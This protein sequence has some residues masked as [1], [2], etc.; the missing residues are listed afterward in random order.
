MTGLRH[1]VFVTPA[2]PQSSGTLNLPDGEPMVWSPLATTLIHGEYDAVLVDP[3]FTTDTTREVLA[4]VEKTGRDLTDICITHGHGD[5]W[6]GVPVLLERFPEAVVRATAGTKAHMT[7]LAT[8]EA[9]GP[10]FT[11]QGRSSARSR[12]LGA[13]RPTSAAA[14]AEPGRA[15][16]QA[17]RRREAAHPSLLPDRRPSG[18]AQA[19]APAGQL[20]APP[21]RAPTGRHLQADRD[22]FPANWSN[23]FH[24]TAVRE[25]D[26]A[27]PISVGVTP[28]AKTVVRGSP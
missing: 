7:A 17:A 19:D 4:W 6:L 15:P 10:S 27:F 25:R 16:G 23:S 9:R 1:D 28:H 5:H 13:C 26:A 21:W 14:N 22:G 12:R 24:P 3:P 20:P 8:P 11:P 2:V 18:C